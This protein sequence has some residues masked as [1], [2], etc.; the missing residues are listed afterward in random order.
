MFSPV[1]AITAG[2]LA[3]A[4]SGAFLIAQPFDQQASVPGAEAEEVAP[5]W[6]TGDIRF[7]SECTGPDYEFVG[8]VRHNRNRVCGPQA[9][10]ASDPRLAGD[11]SRRHNDDVY[12]TDEEG[13]ISV[14]MDAAYLRNDG[15]G[16]ACS[17]SRLLRGSD[18]STEAFAG[19]NFTCVGEDGYEGL[20]AILVVE[21]TVGFN[22]EFVGLIFSGDFP[23]LPE[24]PAE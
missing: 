22:E 9:W 2:A 3:F 7:F 21:E 5:T 19:G 6:V 12:M 15:G 8:D 18:S 13:F 11:V 14:R 23:P 20:S 17:D 24:R 1:K 4:L 16:W 10:T